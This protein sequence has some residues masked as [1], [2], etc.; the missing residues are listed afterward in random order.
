VNNFLENTIGIE[1]N[2]LKLSDLGPNQKSDADSRR[3][4]EKYLQQNAICP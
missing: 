3:L 1:S 4:E 2:P